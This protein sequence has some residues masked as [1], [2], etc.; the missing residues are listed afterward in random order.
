MGRG[1]SKRRTPVV[2]A[3]EPRSWMTIA[4]VLVVMVFAGA[5]FGYAYLQYAGTQEKQA[6]LAP[7][8]PS[9][10]NPDPSKAIPGVAVEQYQGSQHV[11]SPQRVAYDKNPPFGGAHDQYWA[12]CDGV[13][14]DQPFRVENAVHSLEHGAVWIAYRPG[15]VDSAGIQALRERVEGESHM[16]MSPVPTLDTPIALQSWGHQLKLNRANDPRIDQFIQALRTNRFTHP[17]V[18]G[19]C[20]TLGPGAFDPDKP[21]PFQSGRPGPG[22]APVRGGGTGASMGSN[23]G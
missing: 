22:A 12:A 13:V 19:T 17:E 15:A 14:Y 5:I 8:A 16:L 20:Q 10:Q 2:A 21:P 23:G 9:E 11:Q 3:R 4:G 7:F 6:A 18:G 1:T